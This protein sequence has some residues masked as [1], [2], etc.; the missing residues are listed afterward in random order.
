MNSSNNMA[1]G[2]IKLTPIDHNNWY[3]CTQLEVIEEQ[4]SVFPVPVVYWLAESAYCGFTPLAI[5]NGEQLVGLTVYAVDPDDG[6]YWIM[7]YMIDRSHQRKGLGR[8]G[9]QELIRHLA[10]QH[11]CD[12]IILGHRPDN[13]Q[14]ARLYASLGFEEIDRSG[15]EII[16]KLK[17]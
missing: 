15:H 2:Q 6:N 1:Q 10:D 12:Q 14:A 13:V 16:R 8:L 7:A 3:A 11:G 4:R 5:Y 17:L 9:M